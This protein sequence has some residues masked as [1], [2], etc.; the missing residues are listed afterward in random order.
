CAKGGTVLVLGPDVKEE[1]P[2]L[3]LR[4]RHAAVNDGVRILEVTP[5][6]TGLTRYARHSV[7]PIPGHTAEVVRA[8]LDG[9]TSKAVGGVEPAALAELAAAL[10]GG[11][12]TVVVGRGSLAEAAA[13]T[14][15]AAAVIHD[16]LPDARFLPALR[17]SNVFGAL[18]MGLAPGLLPGRV[19]LDEGREWYAGHWPAVPAEVGHDATGILTAAAAGHV[20]TLVLLGADPLVDFP[21]A[22]LAARA[23]AGA[24]TVI[25]LD[26]FVTESVA[27]ADVVF[28]VAGYAE[29]DGTTTNLE[30]RVSRLAKRVTA[31][32]TA[33]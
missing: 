18:D 30:G 2:V 29:C 22:D 33:R 26:Q 9:D 25:A 3:Y 13:V 19:A 31:P 23:L 8:V 7:H 12:V 21:D 14:V 15:D 16:A 6:A 4:L 32:G 11:P 28:P 27:K 10:R 24:R 5:T 1:L 17:R 20:D